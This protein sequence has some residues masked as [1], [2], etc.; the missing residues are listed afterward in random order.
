[1]INVANFQLAH[2]ADATGLV[3]W[4]LVTFLEYAHKGMPLD[5][6]MRWGDVKVRWALAESVEF[7]R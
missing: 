2:M 6:P 7:A 1:M 3:G 5:S 4:H